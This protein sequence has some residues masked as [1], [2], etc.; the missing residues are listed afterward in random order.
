[1]ALFRIRSD[2]IG[3]RKYKIAAVKPEVFIYQIVDKIA[4]PF[5]R[6]PIFGVHEFNVA[7]PNAIRC[8]RKSEIQ[9]GGWQTGNT[10]IPASRQDRNEIPTA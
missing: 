7:I 10:Y 1:M 4:A 9:Y 8:N 3:R 6:P 5:Q 2:V